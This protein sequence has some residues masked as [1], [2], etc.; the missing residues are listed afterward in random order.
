MHAMLLSLAVACMGSEAAA[1]AFDERPR[2][3]RLSE[4]RRPE[5]RIPYADGDLVPEG[6]VVESGFNGGLFA[7]GIA[8]YGFSYAVSVVL[9]ATDV[10]LTESD[11]VE[12]PS[13]FERA[14]TSPG[15][16]EALFVPLIGPWIALGTHTDRPGGEVALLVATGVVQGGG[17]ALLALGLGGKK[18]WL[19]R[20]GATAVTVGAR[21]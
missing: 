5:V 12:Q 19:V 3:P 10:S 14:D 2:K 1:Q 21:F 17:M 18:R 6:F 13:P 20:A 8:V 11:E 16:N 4:E 7:A 9:A 15:R